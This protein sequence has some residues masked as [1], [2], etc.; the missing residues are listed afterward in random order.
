MAQVGH[1]RTKSATRRQAQALS[2]ADERP[3]GADEEPSSSSSSGLCCC[4][5]FKKV[6]KIVVHEAEMTAKALRAA[7]PMELK[8]GHANEE[9]EARGMAPPNRGA[10]EVVNKN[11]NGE[12]VAI[13]VAGNVQE[14]I[15]RDVYGTLN[16]FIIKGSL[17]EGTVICGEFDKD[18][19]ELQVALFYGAK[20]KQVEQMLEGDTVK[21]NFDFVKGYRVQ[22]EGRNVLLKY[23]QGDLHVQ[24]GS[25]GAAFGG[26][27]FVG[28]KRSQ[29]TGIDMSTNVTE[30]EPIPMHF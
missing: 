21:D 24:R 1:M 19:L 15:T 13:I 8:P 17:P 18:A 16:D 25:S 3:A 27:V 7:P 23:K 10:F 11:K 12:I 22:C 4:L 9:G 29:G 28:K 30:L 5:G 20:Y 14:M 26:N 6:A 2:A